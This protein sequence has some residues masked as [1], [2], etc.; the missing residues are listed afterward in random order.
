MQSSDPD[1]ADMIANGYVVST[2]APRPGAATAPGLPAPRRAASTSRQLP[3]V[4]NF[5]LGF[6]SP[7]TY[8]NCQNPDNDPAQG[9]GGEDHERGVQVAANSTVIAQV[10]VHTDHPFWESFVHDSPAHFD[11]IAALAVK[12]SG[13]NYNVTLDATKGVDYTHFKFGAQD[14][15]WRG[16]LTTFTQLHHAQLEPA[17]GLRQSEHPA[18]SGRR[19]E[20]VDARLLRLHDLQPEHA[21]PPQ[22]RRPLLRAAA[23]SVAAVMLATFLAAEVLLGQADAGPLRQVRI[24]VR[25]IVASNDPVLPPGMDPRLDP[26][27]QHLESFGELFRF[28]SLRLLV[29]QSFDLDWHAPAEVELPGSRRLM[30]IPRQLDNEGR[31]ELHLELV[32]TR[33]RA[34][35]RKLHTDYA[36]VRGGTILVGGLDLDPA[37]RKSGKLLIA[38]THEIER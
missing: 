9:L 27:R 1:Y 30:V 13:G 31:I 28:R 35:S 7:T 11:Q 34:W 23:L 24:T 38:V 8:I 17:D 26:I 25:A 4:V 37:I 10:T 5:K 12:D 6:K 14:L 2:S 22:L 20:H 21:G 3:T 16:C 36:I 15:P 18:Q 19:P 29:Q 33:S 32:A